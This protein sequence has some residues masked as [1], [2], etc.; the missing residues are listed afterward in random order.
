M[1][2]GYVIPLALFS[3]ILLSIASG[4]YSLLQP[5]SP[6]GQWVGFQIISGIGSGA[7]LQVVRPYLFVARQLTFTDIDAG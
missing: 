5:G 4:L 6:T 1:K 2:I 7:G 3:T